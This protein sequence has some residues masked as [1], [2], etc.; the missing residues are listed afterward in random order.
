MPQVPAAPENKTP[1][2][3]RRGPLLPPEEQFW[4]RYSP[5]HEFPLSSATSFA[6]HLLIGGLMV[7]FVVYLLSR[8][9]APNQDA[10]SGEPVIAAE[11]SDGNPKGGGAGGGKNGNGLPEDVGE[12]RDKTPAGLNDKGSNTVLEMPKGIDPVKIPDEG[13]SRNIVEGNVR[14]DLD[15]VAK[16][17]HKQ[18]A[19]RNDAKGTGS[20]GRDGGSGGGKDKGRDKGTGSRGQGPGEEGELAEKRAQRQ[21]RWRLIFNHDG[22]GEDYLK[23]LKALGAILVAGD[24][25]LGAN[26][27]PA[28]DARGNVPLQY[29]FLRNFNKKDNREFTRVEDIP[30]IFWIDDKP[31]TVGSLARA[32]RVSQPKLFA[33]FFPIEVEKE[34]RRLE[35]N[36]RPRAREADIDETLFHVDLRNT[37][38]GYKLYCDNVRLKGE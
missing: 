3:S 7:V 4:K 20:K 15:A 18:L 35:K 6:L 17:V 14:D 25:Q 21:L 29:R 8:D 30:G 9:T 10:P 37:S 19:K 32:L 33:C 27:R 23:K 24:Y 31:A 26:G 11:D 2:G 16:E 13:G 5:H 12:N 34:L 22:N 38:P 36:K 28:V 1:A